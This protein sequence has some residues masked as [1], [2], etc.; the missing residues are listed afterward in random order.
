MTG[1][2]RVLTALSHKEPDRVPYDLSGTHVTGIS[3]GAHDRLRKYLSLPDRRTDVVDLLQQLA[4]P[5]DDLMDRLK[6]DTRGL[7]PLCSNNI[8]LPVGS[9]NWRELIT[10]TNEGLTYVDEWGFRQFMPSDG[11]Y[12][13]LVQSPLPDMDVSVEQV[14]QLPL[15][16]GSEA[17]RIEGLRE[18]AERFR[19]AGCCV[20]LKSL[21]AGMVEMGHRVRGMENFLMD[22]LVNQPVAE[23][24][25]ERFLEIKMN[26]WG[27]AL[28]ELGCVV[29]VVFEMDDYGTQTSQLISPETF[30]SIVKPR[31]KR[32][33]GHVKKLSPGVKV[34]FH[35]CGSV[36]PIIPDFIEI[37]IDIL[38][39]VH[40][41]ATGMEPASLKAD[42]GADICFWGGGVETQHV[43]PT[44]TPEKVRA[45]VRANI[46]ALAPGGGWVFTTIHNI[47]QDVPPEN[48]MAMWET[49]QSCG[50]YG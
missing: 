45:D 47:Q 44:G 11:L 39:P 40:I 43:L 1:R 41:S 50:V 33:I 5:A 37:G 36:R 27:R 2:E 6:V 12:F 29:D 48:V 4:M 28:G 19:R 24:V 8:P 22:L 13:S 9:E 26:Y 34:A 49:L 35:S 21:C 17:W 32:L 30:R 38:N 7:Y 15:P 18:Q 42:F 16:D 3:V 25:I 23:A 10:E 31:L 46:D 14:M 20:V